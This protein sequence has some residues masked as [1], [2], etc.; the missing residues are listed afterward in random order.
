MVG[1]CSDLA[2]ILNSV[3]YETDGFKLQLNSNSS[4]NCLGI[5]IQL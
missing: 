4:R 1:N 5:L 3:G 2:R